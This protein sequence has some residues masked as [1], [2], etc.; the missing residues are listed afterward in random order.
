MQIN[1]I[2]LGELSKY[3]GVP[4]ETAW[5]WVRDDGC[6]NVGVAAWILRQ[7]IDETGSVK[8]G[9]AHYH[10]ATPHLGSRYQAKVL[11]ALEKFHGVK[12]P[13]ITMTQRAERTMRTDAGTKAI[14]TVDDLGG[15]PSSA[16]NAKTQRQSS[17]VK[18]ISLRERN[19]MNKAQ[20]AA[21]AQNAQNNQAP[22]RVTNYIRV[23]NHQ[24]KYPSERILGQIPLNKIPVKAATAP[25]AQNAKTKTASAAVTAPLPTAKPSAI[26]L[27]QNADAFK[28]RTMVVTSLENE[29]LGLYPALPQEKPF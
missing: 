26:A 18:V 23:E 15:I 9:I 1:T 16:L 25:S 5:Q 2:W 24:P 27:S 29:K 7:K 13:Q 11:T 19:E 4:R 28:P 20:R 22:K 8:K 17:G 12:P 3:W 21:R 6:I 10:S 14:K